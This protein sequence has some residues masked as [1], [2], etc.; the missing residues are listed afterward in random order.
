MN[1]GI[2]LLTQIRQKRIQ[3]ALACCAPKD[4]FCSFREARGRDRALPGFPAHP[5]KA[6]N[7]TLPQALSVQSH[8]L[9]IA[10]KA[11]ISADLLLAFGIGQTR[12]VSFWAGSS[13]ILF[14]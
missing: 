12:A 8:D 7:A 6:R 13:P 11:L 1:I 3:L 2:P 10:S 14:C 4:A 5:K 9:L